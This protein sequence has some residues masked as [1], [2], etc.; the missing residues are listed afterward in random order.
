MGR[1]VAADLPPEAIN[2]VFGEEGNLLPDQGCLAVTAEYL[3]SGHPAKDLL[4]DEGDL[5]ACHIV[6]MEFFAQGK[7][8][9]LYDILIIAVLV[10]DSEFVA[11]GNNLFFYIEFHKLS[12]T[13]LTH[14]LSK[15]QMLWNH[16]NRNHEC[17]SSNEYQTYSFLRE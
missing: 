13:T 10:L 16:G 4:L 8:L 14:R 3:I 12:S 15:F 5:P 2:A 7:D 17:N 6:N 9:T 11:P 1:K